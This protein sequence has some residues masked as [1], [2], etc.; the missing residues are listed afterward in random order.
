L[1]EFLTK[2]FLKFHIAFWGTKSEVY[3]QEI[4][5]TMLARMKDG[6]KF[7]L[8]FVWSGKES[9]V[10]KFEDGIPIAWGK[11]LQK[12]FWRYLDFSHLNTV[13]IDHKPL[14]LAGIPLG[15]S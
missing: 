9:E 1:I 5:P 8:A 13:M 3:M 14:G 4:V 6:G 10:T 7:S 2:C 11:P 12:V 15:I